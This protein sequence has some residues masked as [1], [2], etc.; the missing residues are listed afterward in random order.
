[1]VLAYAFI[2]I[3][4]L[5]FICPQHVRWSQ[6]FVCPYIYPL[7]P[8]PFVENVKCLYC[9]LAFVASDGN[10]AIIYIIVSLYIIFFPLVALNILSFSLVFRS[11]IMISLGMVY[12]VLICW[13]LSKLLGS[14]RFCFS[15]NLGNF[16]IIFKII[17]LPFCLVLSL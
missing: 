2:A 10:L 4:H 8:V 5:E 6:D 9:L 13:E 16:W 14:I 11:F 12:F 15:S 1:M 17:T 7:A 3:L